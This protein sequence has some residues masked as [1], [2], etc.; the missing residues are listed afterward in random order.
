MM[1]IDSAPPATDDSSALSRP[2]LAGETDAG[3]PAGET[4]LSVE[5]A[6]AAGPFTAA[7]S[8]LVGLARAE[9][10]IRSEPWWRRWL[11]H[12][13]GNDKTLRALLAPSAVWHLGEEM[14]PGNRPE[15]PP[16]STIKPRLLRR[17][18]PG[19]PLPEGVDPAAGRFDLVVSRISPG[20]KNHWWTLLGAWVAAAGIVAVWQGAAWG[21]LFTCMGLS[22]FVS[23]LLTAVDRPYTATFEPSPNGE[24]IEAPGVIEPGPPPPLVSPANRRMT[25]LV[26]AA[27]A[28]IGVVWWGD[29]TWTNRL[30]A[31][32]VFLFF[33]LM[34][35]LDDLPIPRKRPSDEFRARLRFLA[36]ADPTHPLAS[37]DVHPSAEGE[38]GPGSSV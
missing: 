25:L 26:A 23:G 38:R 2:V 27:A 22:G 6:S 24:W 21:G 10:L 28:T 35:V 3:D 33:A 31:I 20:R 13:R 14:I 34:T 37:T 5:S 15:D 30:F 11:D 1:P 12:A 17:L 16:I 9:E 32:G 36:L 4:A 19:A 18:D 8:G 29:M 7:R